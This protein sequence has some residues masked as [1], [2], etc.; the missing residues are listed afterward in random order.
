MGQNEEMRNEEINQEK[1]T[2]GN[3]GNSEEVFDKKMIITAIAMILLM[4]WGAISLFLVPSL[5]LENKNLKIEASNVSQLNELADSME[6][7]EKFSNYVDSID[8]SKGL[9]ANEVLTLEEEYLKF[10]MVEMINEEKVSVYVEE[11]VVK[12]LEDALENTAD[13]QVKNI[14][15]ELLTTHKEILAEK[16]DELR[17]LEDMYIGIENTEKTLEDLLKDGNSI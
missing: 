8:S 5:Y 11:K 14:I 4:A 6:A 9:S 7:I 10:F 3:Q 12:V 2:D 16:T 13:E 17:E 1:R 15:E